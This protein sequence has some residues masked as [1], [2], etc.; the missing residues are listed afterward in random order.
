MC[1]GCDELDTCRAAGATILP[2]DHPASVGAQQ[3]EAEYVAAAVALLSERVGSHAA[4]SRLAL[5]Q[6]VC[7]PVKVF[8]PSR[9]NWARGLATDVGIVLT[10]D[11][12]AAIVAHEVTCAAC[13]RLAARPRLSRVQHVGSTCQ[14]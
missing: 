7:I 6:E 1:V 13:L 10:R 14:Y 2:K 9:L 4:R 12:P 3:L 8:K 11:A 5:P